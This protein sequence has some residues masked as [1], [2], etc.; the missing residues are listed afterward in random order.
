MKPEQRA[1]RGACNLNRVIRKLLT[2]VTILR[3]DMKGNKE[4]SC[5]DLG[6]SIP[7]KC[8]EMGAHEISVA[9]MM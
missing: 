3:R 7:N 1:Q 6:K 2:G 5:A 9:L 4:W 8:L